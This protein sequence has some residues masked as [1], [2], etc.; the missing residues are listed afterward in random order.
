[1]GKE[2]RGKSVD[3]ASLQG[4]APARKEEWERQLLAFPYRFREAEEVSYV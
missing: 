2:E 1:M 3:P 4:I